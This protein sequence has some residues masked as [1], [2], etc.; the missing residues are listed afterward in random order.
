MLV[1]VRVSAA[2]DSL[3]LHFSSTQGFAGGVFTDNARAGYIDFQSLQS[4]VHV[5]KPNLL[6]AGLVAGVRFGILDFLRMETQLTLV[7]G[8]AIDDTLYTAQ[9]TLDE[10]Y[11][12]HA[13]LEPSLQ[14][15]LSPQTWRV[16]PFA[17]CGAGINMMWVDERTFFVNDPGQ[18]VI[19]NDRYYV[20]AV[21]WSVSA[22]AGFG[23]DAKLTRRIGLS[24]V[25]TF[26]YVYP[27]FYNIEEDYPLY[28]M[29]Y[30][31]TVYGVV[32]WLGVTIKL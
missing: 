10:Y 27:V 21:S 32:T 16:L 9:P 29:H 3:S 15:A 5:S 31:E 19:Y 6:T 26:R 7:A 17:V 30:T 22:K 14:C 24:L 4:S 28:S 11:Y 20:N 25:S 8:N 18:E 23:L 2:G 1:F 12:Y 13:A